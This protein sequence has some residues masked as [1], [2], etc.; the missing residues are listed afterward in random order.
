M[1][2]AAS[3]SRRPAIM[4]MKGERAGRP[5]RGTPSTPQEEGGTKSSEFMRRR[6]GSNKVIFKAIKREL[7]AERD[8]LFHSKSAA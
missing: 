5:G 6:E 7:R 4:Q 8:D 1:R 3:D 2:R